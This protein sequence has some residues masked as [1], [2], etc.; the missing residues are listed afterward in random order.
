MMTGQ[1]AYFDIRK[2]SISK[3]H[4]HFYVILNLPLFLRVSLLPSKFFP[5][6]YCENELLKSSDCIWGERPRWTPGNETLL[7]ISLEVRQMGMLEKEGYDFLCGN[8]YL[9]FLGDW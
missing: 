6:L 8:F 2:N 4:F 5:A 9:C 7:L 3:K 1:Y